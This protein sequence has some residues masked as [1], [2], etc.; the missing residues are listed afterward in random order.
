LLEIAHSTHQL[1]RTLPGFVEDFFLEQT[2]GGAT[3]N[4]LTIAVWEN[5]QAFD[6]ARTIVHERYREIGF[7]PAELHRRLGIEADLAVYTALDD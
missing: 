3:S 7:H 1:L 4:F 2:D 5:R 6:S